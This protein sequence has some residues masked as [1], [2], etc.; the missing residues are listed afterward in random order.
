M[1]CSGFAPGVPGLGRQGVDVSPWS[2]RLHRVRAVSYTHLDVYKRQDYT[3]AADGKSVAISFKVKDKTDI[4]IAPVSYTHL[5]P[6]YF[7]ARE[8]PPF[9]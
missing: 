3:V 5:F 9:E 4:A 1:R 7:S 2:P 6:L 8:H